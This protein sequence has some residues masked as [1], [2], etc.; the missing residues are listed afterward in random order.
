MWFV[1]G[2]GTRGQKGGTF[3]WCRARCPDKALPG[4]AEAVPAR[5][6]L[7]EPTPPPCSPYLLVLALLWL[8]CAPASLRLP[9]SALLSV[10][11]GAALTARAQVKGSKGEPLLLYTHRSPRAWAT[12]KRDVLLGQAQNGARAG[13]ADFTAVTASSAALPH[14]PR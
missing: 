8:S 12:H 7:G 13:G 2:V 11:V 10:A 14:D 4:A 9:F 3:C 5:V 1:G 6:L